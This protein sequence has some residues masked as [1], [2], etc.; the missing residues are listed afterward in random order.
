MSAL[1]QAQQIDL[2][3]EE[4]TLD[5]TIIED[6]VVI[7]KVSNLKWHTNLDKAKSAALATNK[8]I[9][10]YFTGS[11]WCAPCKALKEDFFETEAF[12]KRAEN[13]ELVYIDYPRRKDIISE[14]AMKYNR[15]LIEK[16]NKNKTFPKLVML[17]KNGKEL[18]FLGG[19][20]SF[21][22]YKDTSHHFKFVDTYIK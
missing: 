21:N 19:Y 9:L 4:D 6:N 16:Y 18:G 7:E 13:F 20:S 14:N 22:N 11:D 5:T 2:S 10:V 17:D 3:Q 12:E 1:L 8:K 15:T